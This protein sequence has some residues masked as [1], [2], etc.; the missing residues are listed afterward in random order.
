VVKFPHHGAHHLFLEPEGFDTA[1]YYVNGLSTSLPEELQREIVRTVPGLEKAEIVRA[2][3]AIEYD[4]SDPGQ[5]DYTLETR[6]LPGLYTAGQVNGTTGY[7]EAAAQ[8]L[9]AGVNAA[10]QTSGREPLVL[11]RDEAYIGVMIDDLVSKGVDEPYRIFTSRAEYR[12]LLRADNADLRLAPAG[13]RLGLLDP[14]LKK[15]F[16]AYK[17]SVEAAAEG[18]K[19]PAMPE[20]PWTAERARATAAIEKTYAMYVARN[21]RQAEKMTRLES[22]RIPDSFSYAAARAQSPRL[23]GLSLLY[24]P[25]LSLLSFIRQRTKIWT[26]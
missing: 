1:E 20:G 21:R 2:A 23:R 25:R 13:F 7:E 5:L 12:L 24:P 10:L 15:N 6:L 11:K 19:P 17:A 4:Y 22:V 18:E 3:Y 9:I 16:D 14:G 8:G 26:I